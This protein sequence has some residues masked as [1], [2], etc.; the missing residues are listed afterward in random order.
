MAQDPL[1][2]LVVE[3]SELDFELLLA[4][5]Q[6]DRDNLGRRV[7]ARRV[8]DEV[9]L[10]EAFASGRVDALITDHN[11]PRFDS[12]AALRAARALDA[13]LPAIV[14][15]GEMSD[16]LAVAVLQAGADDF[17]LKTRMFRLG[18]ALK[19]SLES[20]ATR[21][22]RRAQALALA[23]SEARLRELT[24]RLEGVREE[25]RR[26]LAQE[27]HDDIGTT[28]T[29][30]KF[31]LARLG[32]DLGAHPV[33]TP[34]VLA[35]NEL[36]AH[37]VAASHR[38]Q[39]NLHPPVLD[40]GLAAALEWLA[41]GFSERTGV[42]ARFESNRDE[43][44]LSASHAAAIY[45]VA[46]EALANCAKHAQAHQVAVQLFA[47]PEEITLE[48]SDDG[49]GFD[50]A[51][52]EATLGLGLRG[53]LERA[54]GLGGWAEVNSAA[55]RGTTLMFSVPAEPETAAAAGNARPAR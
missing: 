5:L 21:R 6:R 50:P 41:R 44:P 24:H 29:A 46:Q 36:L 15:S 13:D 48:V 26:R 27:V 45:R 51:M 42:P 34:R 38:I 40:T 47:G 32:R 2:L 9:G 12:F 33:A 1:S 19:R 54:R 17:I 11:L 18:P 14:L 39:H 25:E 3:D 49:I 35:M 4:V 7:Q 30:L 53:L 23:D 55:G 43:L 8:E 20:A 37:A 28:L 52:L 16:E 22:D 31:E 10:H